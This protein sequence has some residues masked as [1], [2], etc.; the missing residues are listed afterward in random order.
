[1]N[2]L[3]C[4]DGL[5]NDRTLGG[6]PAQLDPG[7]ALDRGPFYRLFSLSHTEYMYKYIYEVDIR[8][9]RIG[10]ATWGGHKE[11]GVGWL[12]R[13]VTRARAGRLIRAFSR[14]LVN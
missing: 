4:S 3:C 10:S 11:N 8:L 7:L 12:R 6:L 1:M 2:P 9:D 5:V 14:K 13:L